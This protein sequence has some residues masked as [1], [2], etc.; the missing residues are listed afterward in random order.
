MTGSSRGRF[1]RQ[2]VVLECVTLLLNILIISK[3]GLN[4]KA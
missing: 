1:A 3:A 2:K 4:K